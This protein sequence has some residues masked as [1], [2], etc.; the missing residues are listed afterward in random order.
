MSQS[1]NMLARGGA[2]YGDRGSYQNNN[3]YGGVG[4]PGSGG[5]MMPPQRF[6]SEQE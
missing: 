1:D 6:R 5:P 3:D 2:P 4:G